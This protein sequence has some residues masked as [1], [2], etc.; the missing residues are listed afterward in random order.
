MKGLVFLFYS[1]S[2]LIIE[3]TIEN[4]VTIRFDATLLV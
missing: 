1:M 2:K 3:M 4:P